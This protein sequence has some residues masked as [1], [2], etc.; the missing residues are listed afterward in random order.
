MKNDPDFMDRVNHDL[1]ARQA[2]R[3]I[4]G[5]PE[6]ATAEQL[7]RAY[8][9]AAVEQH[10][11]HNGNTAEANRRFTLIRQAFELLAFD[12][13]CDALLDERDPVSSV[14]ADE[15]YRLDNRWG[16]FC[17]WREKFLGSET[18]REKDERSS[19]I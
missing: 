11:D 1:A 9:D 13:P 2:A 8:R 6:N 12:R 16:H 19:C 7:K 18:K 10:P 14:P 15:R 4:L 17:W 5:V 3:R